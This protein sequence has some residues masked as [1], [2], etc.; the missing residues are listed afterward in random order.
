MLESWT[1]TEFRERIARGEGFQPFE[2][3]VRD[4]TTPLVPP[5]VEQPDMIVS[6]SFDGGRRDFAVEIKA[7]STPQTLRLAIMQ[8]KAVAFAN[9]A[10]SL[11][12]MVVL[13]Y[14]RPDALD[15]LVRQRTSGVDL[16]GNG[17]IYVPGNWFAYRTGA[18][19]KYPSSEPIK[20]PFRGEQSIVARCLLSRSEF[21]SQQ[22]IVAAVAE[23]GVTQ[24]TVSKVLAAL[25]SELMAERKPVIRT[26]R[27]SALLDALRDNYRVPTPRRVR[28]VRPVAEGAW[29]RLAENAERANVRYAVSAPERYVLLPNASG[30]KR[31]L[32]TNV[33]ALLEKIDLIDDDRFP[34]MELVEVST[35]AIFFGRLQEGNTWFTAPLQEYL[36]LSQAGKREREAAQQMRP[37]LLEPFGQT[38]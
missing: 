10:R 23:F 29:S 16:C 24:S 2:V 26:L 1:I 3:T 9:Q 14:L 11:L 8:A 38:E 13:P 30:V 6:L 22:D 36:E 32:T 18:K 28:R 33:E 34:E 27:P 35:N 25:S 7:N 31:V 15:E 37:R 12:P 19:N 21:R 4:D 17:V 20:N 5:A